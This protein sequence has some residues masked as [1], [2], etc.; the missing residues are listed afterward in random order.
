MAAVT[1]KWAIHRRTVSRAY[2]LTYAPVPWWK[3]CATSAVAAALPD[4]VR[5]RLGIGLDECLPKDLEALLPHLRSYS[6]M[7]QL[8][9]ADIERRFD[10][11][12]YRRPHARTPKP[13]SDDPVRIPAQWEP[14]EAVAITWPICFP[15]IW[16]THAQLA[17]AILDTGTAAVVLTPSRA[18]AAVIDTVVSPDH[19]SSIRYL[20]QPTDDIWIRDYGPVT[21]FDADANR[22]MFASRYDPPPAMP[23][24]LDGAV[25]QALAT[26]FDAEL[27]K[28]DWHWE[29]GN[30]WTSGAGAHFVTDGIFDRN[31]ALSRGEVLARIETAF[32]T[33]KIVVLPRLRSEITGHVDL[34]MKLIGPDQAL[35]PAGGPNEEIFAAVSHTLN[36]HGIEI[37]PLPAVPSIWNFGFQVWPSHTNALT[38]NGHILVPTYGLPSDEEALHAYDRAG[39]GTVVPVES[40]VLS[41]AGGAVHCVTMQI[42][43]PRRTSNDAT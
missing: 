1:S 5:R 8:S 33:D 35:V 43:A 2:Q 7:P 41:R 30:F 6:G 31:P 40:S 13:S 42:P 15:P 4:R 16:R 34:V 39:A 9:T 38:V 32:S 27:R 22:I 36:T 18:M 26:E 3:W 19:A 11:I 17:Q 14:T 25:P 37:T 29:P 28:I 21:G 24:Q 23:N 12:D 10:Q 20:E